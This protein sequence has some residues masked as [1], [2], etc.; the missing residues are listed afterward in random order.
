MPEKKEKS[1]SVE[2]MKYKRLEDLPYIVREKL[3][4]HAQEIFM[5]AHNNALEQ[6]QDPSERRGGASLEETAHKVAW[7]AVEQEYEKSESGNWVKKKEK[8]NLN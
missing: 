7:A 6:Y 3:P 8:S 4:A 5:K 2:E 1:E